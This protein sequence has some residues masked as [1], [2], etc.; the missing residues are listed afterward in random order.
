MI[1]RQGTLI[2][3]LSGDSL[4]DFLLKFY[5]ACIQTFSCPGLLWLTQYPRSHMLFTPN[6]I[7]L[8]NPYSH[9]VHL[10]W[11]TSDPAI[12]VSL[13]YFWGIPRVYSAMLKNKYTHI[14][15]LYNFY[16]QCPCFVWTCMFAPKVD[17][18]K[19]NICSMVEIV[20]ISVSLCPTLT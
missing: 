3:I 20:T 5:R 17:S 18:C 14:S 19:S 12:R 8:P 9:F 16:N 11:E 2:E 7:R 15:H 13:I 1:S 4:Q 6:K 10:I